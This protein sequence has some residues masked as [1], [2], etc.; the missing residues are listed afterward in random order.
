MADEKESKPKEVKEANKV[1][2]SAPV[3]KKQPK[4]EALKAE[5]S[6]KKSAASPRTG[7]TVEVVIPVYQKR[8]AS[9]ASS[10]ATAPPTS[11]AEPDE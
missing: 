2:E 6:T 7:M 10:V 9:P 8:R 11:E 4:I 1:K 5:S 3:A